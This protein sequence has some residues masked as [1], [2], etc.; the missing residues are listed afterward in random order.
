[1]VVFGL[2]VIR[3]WRPDEMHHGRCHVARRAVI[4]ACRHCEEARRSN[5]YLRMQRQSAVKSRAY[6]YQH[7]TDCFDLY[8]AYLIREKSS[9]NDAL[10]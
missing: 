1:M 9:R 5:L 4:T 7:M 2:L 6:L 8:H 10:E 3:Y